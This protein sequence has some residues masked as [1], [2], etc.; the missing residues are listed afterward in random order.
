MYWGTLGA[1]EVKRN[2][3][4]NG[5]IFQGK[6]WNE[7]PQDYFKDEFYFTLF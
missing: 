1:D 7:Y 6:E 2:K 5:R 3:K 4:A